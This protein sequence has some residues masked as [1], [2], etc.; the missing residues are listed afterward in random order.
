MSNAGGFKSLTR[1]YD[2]LAGNTVWNPWEPAGAYDAL[3]SVT[4]SASTSSITFA[5]IPSGYKHLQI[6]YSVL[7]TQVNQYSFLRFNGDTT[8]SNYRYHFIDAGGSGTPS[9]GT[10]QNAYSGIYVSTTYPGAGILDILD[11]SDINKFKT[12]RDLAGSDANGSGNMNYYS[13]LWMSTSAITSINFSI[14]AGNYA[15]TTTFALYGVK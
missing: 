12:T 14:Q 11:Y 7:P 4:L 10:A 15:A 6:R 13:N 5:G 8:T 1:Y 9:S 2:M 3:A